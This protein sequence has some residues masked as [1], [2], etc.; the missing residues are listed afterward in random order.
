VTGS[1]CLVTFGGMVLGTMS[2][3]G[4]RFPDYGLDCNNRAVLRHRSM[5]MVNFES[6][7]YAYATVSSLYLK[8]QSKSGP[9]VLNVE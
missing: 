5:R 2:L 3:G 6:N 9:V 1:I 8:T 4:G 7:P